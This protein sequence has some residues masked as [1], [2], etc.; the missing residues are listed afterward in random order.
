MGSKTHQIPLRE[1]RK[2]VD[3][4]PSDELARFP[5]DRLP[6]HI[7]LD[8]IDDAPPDIAETIET[9]IF[10]RQSSVMHDL[11]SLRQRLGPKTVEAYDMASLPRNSGAL[12]ALVTRLKRFQEN[13]RHPPP[14][15][16]HQPAEESLDLLE[17]YGGIANDV[18]AYYKKLLRA[19]KTLRHPDE[20]YPASLEATIAK[21][22]R[23]LQRRCRLHR[24]VLTQYYSQRLMLTVQMMQDYRERIAA[25]EKRIA[26]QKVLMT[27]MKNRLHDTRKKIKK[28][29]ENRGFRYLADRLVKDLEKTKREQQSMDIPLG[30][31]DLQTWL[32]A[33][34]D[35]H[36]LRTSHDSLNRLIIRAEAL[37][38]SLLK[39]YYQIQEALYQQRYRHNP[40][41][42]DARTIIGFSENSQNFLSNYF[43]TRQKTSA[44]PYWLPEIQRLE[45][46]RKLEKRFL[47]DE[48][49]SQ[50]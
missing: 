42:V 15:K 19:R 18:K 48:Q 35:Y 9:L 49:L 23:K 33:I 40:Q 36:L 47:N 38:L 30:E 11:K 34:V 50:D 26:G 28:F 4:L 24:A 16:A 8:I 44:S 37:F 7:P 1:F 25:H 14:G 41:K 27:Q 39:H 20:H 13:L 46:L 17:S 29:P 10:K 2:L 6:D 3:Q 45:N 31:N 5:V 32:D 12:Q 21:I 43:Q 22:D